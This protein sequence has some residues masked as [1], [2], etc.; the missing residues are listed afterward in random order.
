[1][2][3]VTEEGEGIDV[4]GI[5]APTVIA[6]ECEKGLDH[7]PGDFFAKGQSWSCWERGLHKRRGG[8]GL[9]NGISGPP[10]AFICGVRL[11]PRNS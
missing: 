4:G 2:G 9:D 11:H 8:L 1:M 7:S 3:S 5:L 10:E 6:R